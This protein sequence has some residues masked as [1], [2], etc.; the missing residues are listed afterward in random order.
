[1]SLALVTL[2]HACTSRSHVR[3]GFAPAGSHDGRCRFVPVM[4]QSV[5][6]TAIIANDPMMAPTTTL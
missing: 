3:N 1:M 5:A 6:T 2:S 4:W